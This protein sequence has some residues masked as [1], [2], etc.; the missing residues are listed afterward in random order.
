M[1]IQDWLQRTADADQQSPISRRDAELIGAL[2]ANAVI[3]QRS[4][5]RKRKRSTSILS[6]QP[7][8]THWH[9]RGE[10]TRRNRSATSHGCSAAEESHKSEQDPYKR[11]KRRKTRRDRYDVK[12]AKTQNKS[13][14]KRGDKTKKER[15]KPKRRARGG[16]ESAIVKDYKAKNVSASRLTV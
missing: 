1:D 9:E 6:V 7:S 8:Q 4:N 16:S 13:R 12:P 10:Q 2:S 14:D 15:K 11:R 3:L 5:I